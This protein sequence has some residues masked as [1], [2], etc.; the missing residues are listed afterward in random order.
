MS[1]NVTLVNHEELKAFVCNVFKT[2]GLEKEEALFHAE[3]L[4]DTSLR[5]V[6][7]HGV[8]RVPAYINRMLN[9][10]I[11]VKPSI[12]MI[13]GSKGLQVLDGDHASGFTVGRAA[14]EKAIEVAKEHN[15]G[16]V[17]AINSN[18]FGAASLY[19]RMAAEEGMV[20]I[21]M[22]NVLP[23]IVAPGASEPVT[24]NNPFAISIPTH[25]EIPFDLDMS[26]SKVAG[27]KLTL[28]IKKGEKIPM[29]WATD[30]EGKPTDDPQEAFKGFL[31][32]MGDYK[33][34]GLSYAVDILSGLITGG[35][36]SH[37]LKSM[38]AKPQDPS[39]TSHMMI[40]IN[41]SA[42]IGKDEMKSRM[43]QYIDQLKE[44]PMWDGSEM[45]F[46]GELE[47]LK[48]IERKEKG[49]PIPTKTFEEL[50]QVAEKMN[51][52]FTL[53]ILGE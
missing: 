26:L 41:L 39:L 9:G 11:N 34:L 25:G 38:Y 18:H 40:A 6:D 50:Q 51:L 27:G 53:Q 32:P 47:H 21:A 31:M 22:T 17:G 28:A 29:D 1:E 7:S 13:R 4:V 10:A 12:N 24:G 8:M 44:T 48:L 36:F 14:M 23:L 5:G 20:G 52:P 45:R 30:S 16:A 19:A 3:A 15:V 35:A 33:G 49:V 46:P 42:I 37:Q 43:E 2:A